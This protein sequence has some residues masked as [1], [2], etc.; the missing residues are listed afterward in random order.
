MARMCLFLFSVYC[1]SRLSFLREIDDGRLVCDF[2]YVFSAFSLG[3]L[4]TQ[5][6]KLDSKR[7]DKRRGENLSWKFYTT[8]G[9]CRACHWVFLPFSF[10]VRCK[11]CWLVDTKAVCGVQMSREVIR[12]LQG[13]FQMATRPSTSCWCGR[14]N[15]NFESSLVITLR[16]LHRVLETNH[17]RILIVLLCTQQIK[18]NNPSVGKSLRAARMS[19]CWLHFAPSMRDWS[20]WN[21][22]INAENDFPF[23]CFLSQHPS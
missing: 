2:F 22:K 11:S 10:F 23:F 8:F 7:H 14:L 1:S 13:L 18:H 19:N 5:A 4:M 6:R 21:K 20:I 15:V 9:S 3:V 16:K 12:T 17:F